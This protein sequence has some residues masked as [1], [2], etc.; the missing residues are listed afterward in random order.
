MRKCRLGCQVNDLVASSF[1]FTCRAPT[2]FWDRP[3][4]GFLNRAN[5]V[6]VVRSK[7]LDAKSMASPHDEIIAAFQE[8]DPSI[9]V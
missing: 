3:E 9:S 4:E 5:F 7:K 2:K 6:D 8:V 1:S